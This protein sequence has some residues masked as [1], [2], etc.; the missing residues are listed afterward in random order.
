MAYTRVNWQNSPSHATPLSAENLNVMDAGIASLDTAVTE[1][2]GDISSLE[3]EVGEQATTISGLQTT[4]QGH[5]ASIGTLANLTT[6]EKSNLVGAINE[7]DADVSDLKEDLEQTQTQLDETTALALAAL[8]QETIE[9]VAIASFDDGGDGVPVK[10]LKIAIEPIQSGSGDPSPT[11]VR[12]IS[13]RDSVTVTRT[14]VNVWD[15]EWEVGSINITT[16]EN[17]TSS[18]VIR[19]KN[20][21]PVISGS[22]YYA[23]SSTSET[24]YAF[25]YGFDHEYLGIAR[26]TSNNSTNVVNNEF[27]LVDGTKYIRFRLAQNYGT[28]YNNDIS[29][30]YPSTDHDYHSGADNASYPIPLSST[31]YGGALDVGT[32]V[33]TV[34]RA[35]V[36]FDGSEDWASATSQGITFYYLDLQGGS[37]SANFYGLCSKYPMVNDLRTADKT[38]RC[39]GG[40]PTYDFSRFGVRDSDYTDLASFKVGISGTQLVYEL[41]TPTTVQLTPTQVTT[42]LK[43]NNIFADSGNIVKLI[44]RAD[45]GAYIEKLINA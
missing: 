19:S 41:A 22:N 18:I 3:T 15:E 43:D 14:G 40:K 5:T 27:Y 11:N 13:G 8:P 29:I 26:R 34:D 12:P 10:E 6:T 32:G 4:V 9:N 25:C 31:I 45:L 21:I 20:Y 17:E 1:A 35:M 16:G 36:T 24:L 33:L 28:T 37:A 42:L 7:V 44:Y 23:N 39:Y 2:E 38:C 30:N